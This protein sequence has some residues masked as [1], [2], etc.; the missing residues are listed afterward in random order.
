VRQLSGLGRLP[1]KPATELP[2]AERADVD[3]CVIGGGPAGLAAATAAATAGATTLLVDDQLEL[4]GCLLADPRFGPGEAGRRVAAARAAGVTASSS[5][6]AIAFFPEDDGGVLAVAT[7]EHLLR[8][9]ARQYVWATGGYPVNLLFADNDRPGVLAARAVGRL[10]VQH[11]VVAGDRVVVVA[12]PGTADYVG[13]LVNALAT[14]GAEAHAVDADAVER[15]RGRSWVTAIELT[16]RKRIDCDVIAVAA[17]PSPASDGPRQQGCAVRL[18]PARGGFA[19][20]I[21]DAGRTTAANVWACGDVC[22]YVGPVRAQTMG[23]LVGARAA[24]EVR[25]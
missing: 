8:V 6:T 5:S 22:G 12:A 14:A 16:G 17:V 9:H 1:A 20:Q 4:G 13:A 24:A 18:D 10:L 15:A 2:A 3:V 23:E 25:A 11:G 21:D 19:V 7:P